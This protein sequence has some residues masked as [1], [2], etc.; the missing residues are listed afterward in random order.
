M[1]TQ[2]FMGWGYMRLCCHLVGSRSLI[3]LHRCHTTLKLGSFAIQP[4]TL[5]NLFLAI[6]FSW[7]KMQSFRNFWTCWKGYNDL[8]FPLTFSHPPKRR[9]V[10]YGSGIRPVSA[11]ASTLHFILY[12]H[13]SLGGLFNICENGGAPC[14]PWKIMEDFVNFL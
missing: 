12:M 4:L 1:Y 7:D 3:V 6:V 11:S 10:T 5:H 2:G 9:R 13:I 14:T 8:Q